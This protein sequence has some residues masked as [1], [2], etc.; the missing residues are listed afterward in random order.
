[1]GLAI[2]PGRLKEELDAIAGVLAGGTALL[3]AVQSQGAEHPLAQ[4]ASWIVELAGRFGTSL[5]RE[6][7]VKT[8]QN[9]VGIK[10][11][12]ILEHAGVYKRTPEGQA[13][14]RRNKY[15]S[16]KVVVRMNDAGAYAGYVKEKWCIEQ[17]AAFGI[18]GP[19]ALSVGIVDETAYMIQT[20]VEGDNGLDSTLPKSDVW[21][22]LGQYAKRIHSIPV[23]GYGENLADPVQGEFHSPAHQGSD[24]SWLGY[25]QHNINS[26]TEE[27]RLIELGVL[28]W[29][30]SQRVRE[31][32]KVLKEETFRFGLVH[33]DLSLK[34][35]I[36]NQAGQVILI[37]W[38]NAEVRTVP[39]GDM[40]WVMQCRILDG[41]PETEEF[42][43][44]L[45][46]YGGINAEDH[47]EMRVMLLLKAF[48][49]LRWAIDRSPDRIGS[50]A[51]FA[52]QVVDLFIGTLQALRTEVPKYGKNV[53]L[54]YGG[55][56]IKRSGLY[57]NVLAE[58]NAVG[59]VVTEL[60]GVEPNPR[61]S[62][63]HKGVELCRENGIELIL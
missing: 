14:F 35:T 21:R 5:T 33:G 23:K 19:E 53:L 34:N 38:G 24:G 61:L 55:G 20:F 42:Q 16:R 47:A 29:M 15:G 3:E 59:A 54:M 32:F 49:N 52:K 57:D 30:Q 2:L 60:A 25:V 48:D 56:S 40:I 6:E 50:Y 17:A 31:Q 43:A 13:A 27:D 45:D 46:G 22:Q 10:F 26:L 18:P 51:D 12:H 41:V 7:A 8:I 36:V 39:H 44:F 4:H 1:M 11:T 28:T 62:T 37:D 58:L 9:E 63:V